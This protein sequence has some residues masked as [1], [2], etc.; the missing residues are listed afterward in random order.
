VSLAVRDSSLGH[1]LDQVESGL[2]G[3][4]TPG[5]VNKV[6]IGAGQDLQ[7]ELVLGDE[8]GWYAWE[9]ERPRK[10]VIAGDPRLPLA[11]Q[12]ADERFAATV[13]VLAYRPGRRL[14]L[15]D[16][17]AAE[18]RV[19]KGYRRGHLERMIRRYET[20]HAALAGQGVDTP[21]VIGR[22]PG[23]ECLAMAHHPGDRLALTA[24]AT[25]LFHLV[26]EALRGF[27]EHRPAPG[28]EL[29]DR[30]AELAVL[31]R[32][33]GR[34]AA[35]AGGLPGGWLE[36]RTRLEAAQ[37]GLPAAVSGL[38]HRDLHDKQFVRYSDHLTL[39]DFDLLCMADIT[40]DPANFLAHLVLRRL[41]GAAGATQ[42]S[43]DACGKKFLE[44]LGRNAEP[45]FWERLRFYQAT[46][47]CRLALVYALRPRWVGLVPDLVAMGNRCLDDLQRIRAQ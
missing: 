10:L 32:R 26:G 12:L 31:D 1:M 40:L 22:D 24:E 17:G 11:A 25:D 30:H 8:P 21:A 28:H 38:A 6:E 33:A 4:G 3:A 41:Q 42:R 39:L 15:L 37:A 18:P 43:I 14:T 35:A 34:L 19:L 27:Q 16:R 20:A 44:G 36:L 45:G 2:L 47:F 23:R 29:F 9:R 13:S 7:F 5:Y 46:S